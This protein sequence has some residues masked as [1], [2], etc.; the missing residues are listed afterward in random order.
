MPMVDSVFSSVGGRAYSS[1]LKMVT[2][3]D[4]LHYFSSDSSTTICKSFLLLLPPLKSQKNNYKIPQ[5][6][7]KNLEKK[8]TLINSY[9]L[10]FFSKNMIYAIEKVFRR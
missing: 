6:T 8:Y 1:L 4:I 10:F 5:N 3:R 9:K 7:A 2:T